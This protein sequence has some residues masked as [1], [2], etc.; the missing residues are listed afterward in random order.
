M[1]C[2][3][4]C[5]GVS[6]ELPV[7]QLVNPV[8][9]YLGPDRRLSGSYTLLLGFKTQGKSGDLILETFPPDP[10]DVNIVRR[11]PERPICVSSNI[12]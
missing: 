8:H 4:L 12:R 3:L 2:V 11:V 10:L 1:F 6:S 7:D 5:L 9:F